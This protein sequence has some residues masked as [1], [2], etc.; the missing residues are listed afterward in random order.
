MTASFI[1]FTFLAIEFLDELVFGGVEAA[2]PLIRDDL[3]LNYLQIGALLSL[4]G[5]I[6]NLVEPFLGIL[7]DTW[8]R[9]LIILGGG[10]LFVLSLLLTAASWGYLPLLIS[11]ILFYPASGA[12]VSISQ[13]TLMDAEP[14]RREQNMARWT[15][16]GSLGVVIGPLMLGLL[17]LL[18]SGWRAL[19]VVF[20]FLALVL[21]GFAWRLPLAS[22]P[23][24]SEPDGAAGNDFR[25][26]ASGLRTLLSA[27]RRGEVVRWLILL[28]SANLMLDILLGF[29]AL[30]FVDVAHVTP[31][32]AGI[33]VAIWTG[34]GLLGD[35]LLIRLLERLP[36]LTYLR[37]S[38]VLEFLLFVA[39]L[40]LPGW[41]GK[42]VPLALLG[43]FNSGWYAILQAKLYAAMP[44]QSGSVLAVSNVS[45]LIGSLI[46]L[47]L[48]WVA[49]RYNLQVTMWLLL[50]GPIAL[51]L[52][53]PRATGR[54]IERD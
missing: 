17:V 35:L 26:F 45:G 14:Q 37:L 9:R 10:V 12:F 30:Y 13:A 11:F 21:L 47:A 29:L 43:F 48:G 25:Q 15:F 46:P 28:E 2:W 38:A 54:L 6:S 16:A 32:Q 3:A 40:L 7:A 34:V 49:E 42:L 18:G 33:G 50:L 41:I 53:L 39:F 8:R 31:A 51:I 52:G 27:L 22:S 36:G 19:F 1:M 24:L 20:A 5:I 44:G 4:P 23:A